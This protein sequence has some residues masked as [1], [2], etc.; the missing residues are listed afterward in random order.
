M[1]LV[2]G[3]VLAMALVTHR[4]VRVAAAAAAQML[5]LLKTQLMPIELLLPAV[6]AVL[7]YLVHMDMPAGTVVIL[8]DLTVRLMVVIG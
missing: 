2:V 6:A 4:M 8:L 5:E 1:H 7:L 3:T